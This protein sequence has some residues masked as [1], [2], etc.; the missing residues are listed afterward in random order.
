MT[1]TLY[2]L[3]MQPEIQNKLRKEILDALNK[4]NDSIT[5]DMVM[6]LPYL[7]LVVSETLR[8]YPTLPFLECI[9]TETYK[10][11]NSDLVLEKGTP[12]YIS[13]LGMHYDSEYFPNPKKYNP[14]RFSEE[15]KRNISSGAYF[16]FGEGP[17]QCIG[18]PLDCLFYRQNYYVCTS[19]FS[20]H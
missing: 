1:F 8:L 9:T 13:M 11:P 5:Y 19:S 20:S 15:N 16:P 17:R 12:I 10:M 18:D 14:E 7:D 4:A 3:A 2:E 6:S